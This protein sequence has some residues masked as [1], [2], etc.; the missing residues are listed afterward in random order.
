MR[1]GFIDLETTGLPQQPS[2]DVY[3][4]YTQLKRYT[5]ARIIQI[6]L[7]VYDVDEK[8]ETKLVSEHDYVVKP[9]GFEIKNSHIHGIKQ[10]EAEFVGINFID[11]VN[12]LSK[13]LES[14]D[15]L[16]AH[17]ILFDRNVFLSELYRYGQND[18]IYKINSMNYF[19]TSKGCTEVTKI[20]FNARE[21]KQPKLKELYKFLFKEEPVGLHNALHDTRAM[22][23]CFFEML[24]RGILKKQDGE[25][26]AD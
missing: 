2:Y 6:A 5:N 17:N 18:L 23:K 21:Y 1:I 26:Y 14:C 19:C 3:Y 9:D 4:P 22:I 16:V 24:K 10:S 7:I 20:R 12:K 13:D 25:F 8:N 15:T 11:A